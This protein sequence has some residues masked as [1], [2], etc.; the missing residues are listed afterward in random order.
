M[1][2][3]G[4]MQQMMKQMQKVQKQMMEAQDNL[5]QQ[6]FEGTSQSDMVKVL[7]SGKREVK[8]V[9]IAK[10]A[11]DPEDIELLQDLVMMATNEA[12]QKV[13]AASDQTMGKFTKGLNI[14]G[15]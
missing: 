9:I 8:Q 6:V 14:P 7:V 11:V 2:G 4:N 3:M 5:H 13:E 15:F 12:L 1:R 10:E